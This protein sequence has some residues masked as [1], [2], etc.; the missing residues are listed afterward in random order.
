MLNFQRR[1]WLKGGNDNRVKWLCD[2]SLTKYGKSECD[3][4]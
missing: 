4:L 1:D 2:I 3:G